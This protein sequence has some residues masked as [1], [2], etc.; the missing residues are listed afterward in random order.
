M[1]KLC[2]WLIG[3]HFQVHFLTNHRSHRVYRFRQFS[4]DPFWPITDHTV[5]IV[6]ANF[7]VI[8]SD[9]S[10]ITPCLS[11]PPIFMWYFLNNH[12]YTDHTV[13]IVSANFHVIFSDHSQI[14]PCL[15]SPPIFMWYFLNNQL[16]RSRRVYRLS[17]FSCHIFWPL[18][19][20]TVFIVTANFHVRLS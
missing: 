3:V 5:F 19:D 17:Q 12:S 2:L 15:S 8:F 13:F 4:C 7:H 11:S 16:Y 1:C 14:A 6:S 20:H 10:Q 18:T 9:H